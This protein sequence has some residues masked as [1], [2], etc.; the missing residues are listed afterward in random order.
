M[1][2]HHGQVHCSE[3][4]SGPHEA[5]CTHRSQL[6]PGSLPKPVSIKFTISACIIDS[7]KNT[8]SFLHTLAALVP[9]PRLP[10]LIT[11]TV[12]VIICWMFSSESGEIRELNQVNWPL[13][14]SALETKLDS[15]FQHFG[16]LMDH[17]PVPYYSL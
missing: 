3:L 17:L 12:T 9:S 6:L 5:A 15:V 13:L 4:P 8:D 11:D 2:Q 10:N 16:T 14:K 7:T 1:F